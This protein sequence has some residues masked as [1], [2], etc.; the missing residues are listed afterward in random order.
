MRQTFLIKL[1]L[2]LSTPEELLF[3]KFIIILKISDSLS[4]VLKTKLNIA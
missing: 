4:R 3:L 2:K 1:A